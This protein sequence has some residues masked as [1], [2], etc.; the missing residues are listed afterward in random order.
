MHY[1]C[2]VRLAATTTSRFSSQSGRVTG[3][4]TSYIT[5]PPLG[6][7]SHSPP[8]SSPC[9]PAYPAQGRRTQ[10]ASARP[11]SLRF[12]HCGLRLVS[13]VAF[14]AW[15]YL[16]EVDDSALSR[17]PPSVRGR[18]RC[19]SYPGEINWN[20]CSMAVVPVG[21]SVGG[22]VSGASWYDGSWVGES[23]SWAISSCGDLASYPRRPKAYH[24]GLKSL[25]SRRVKG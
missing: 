9:H 13:N 5:S 11:A 7:A 20:H 17:V 8:S 6:S 19:N 24:E 12:R 4:R 10:L 1:F 15:V 23:S 16:R 22:S 2:P 3:H 18:L 21:R 25:C 14:R